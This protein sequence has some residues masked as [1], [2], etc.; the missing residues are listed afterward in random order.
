MLNERILNYSMM[1]LHEVTRTF[2]KL[3]TVTLLFILDTC[4]SGVRF[5]I[6][7]RRAKIRMGRA[8][9]AFFFPR[10]QTDDLRV[11]GLTVDRSLDTKYQ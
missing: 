3:K 8:L 4:E 5:R 2:L 1:R 6:N 9:H 10:I 11:A 7:V